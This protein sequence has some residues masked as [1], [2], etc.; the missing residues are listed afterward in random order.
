MNERIQH[1]PELCVGCTCFVGE[2]PVE[3]A[4]QSEQTSMARRFFL[5][6]MSHE[7]RT[8]MNA[9]IGM[10][11]LGMVTEDVERLQYYFTKINDASK[12]LLEIIDT[13]MDIAKKECIGVE[14]PEYIGAASALEAGIFDGYT[15]LLAEDMEINREIVL[16]LLEQTR[17]QIDCAVNGAE[18]VR[19]FSAD[20]E[21]YHMVFMDVQMP[22][23]DGYEATRRIRNLDL[24]WAQRIP[25]IAMTANVYKEDIDKCL[26]V[27]MDGHVGKPLDMA[28][29]QNILVHYLAAVQG[30]S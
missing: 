15:I 11:S 4:L 12:H 25:I 10:S 21:R 22:E 23:M 5:S 24:Q 28:E 1:D 14:S 29:V 17:L 30:A 18:A 27:G 2:C 7:I 13:I 8:P 26:E 16:A 3:L 6:N 9:I 19:M 20:P